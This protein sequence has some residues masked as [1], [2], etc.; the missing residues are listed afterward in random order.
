MQT[1][2]RGTIPTDGREQ[3]RRQSPLVLGQQL[4]HAG[5]AAD[6]RCHLDQQFGGCAGSQTVQVLC[7]TA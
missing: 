6:P 2:G 7:T 4:E 5:H 3:T 1:P